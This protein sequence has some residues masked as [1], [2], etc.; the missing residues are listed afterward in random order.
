MDHARYMRFKNNA[1]VLAEFAARAG[2]GGNPGFSDTVPLGQST[3]IDMCQ[4]NGAS[5]IGEA[6]AVVRWRSAT[7]DWLEHESGD[8]VIVDASSG[9]TAVYN[10]TGAAFNLSFSY[11]G[12]G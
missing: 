4:G 6:W 10:L 9:A 12:L 7:F 11:Q 8:N 3:T 1:G 5:L 2:N